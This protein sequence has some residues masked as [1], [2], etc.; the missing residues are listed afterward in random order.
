MNTGV[1]P[2]E[3][4]GRVSVRDGV[5]VLT[6][7]RPPV[8]AL[9]VTHWR[10]L[11]A[12]L[13]DL[14]DHRAVVVTGSDGYFCAGA[15]VREL[16]TARTREHLALLVGD[17]AAA[18]HQVIRLL[19]SGPP[20]VAAVNG[21]A[22]GGGLGI[23]LACDRR[24]GSGRAALTTGFAKL[25]LTPDSGTSFLL[26]AI[27]GPHRAQELL[28]FDRVLNGADALEIELLD[29]LVDAD[30]LMT[31]AISEAECLA[32]RASMVAATRSLVFGR[33]ELDA[34]L[35]LEART[36]TDAANTDAALRRIRE[37]G[38]AGSIE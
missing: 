16:Q 34:H 12:M 24:V 32:R 21:A 11:A 17:T 31:S 5:A 10:A 29:Q 13:G 37:F 18:A 38:R 8:N 7:D 27:V 22:A 14:S 20:V 25:G 6:I 15:D 2:H 26:P 1:A 36:I 35:D 28:M 9:G 4:V 23:A 33:S 3:P 30:Q 19:A